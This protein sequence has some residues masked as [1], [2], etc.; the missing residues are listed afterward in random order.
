M[1]SEK[2]GINSIDPVSL[3]LFIVLV[4]LGWM[5]IYASSYSE[6]NPSI[7]DISQRYGKQLLWIGTALVLGFIVLILDGKVYFSL[8]YP[9]YLVSMLSLAGVLIFGNEVAGAR[10]WYSIGGFSLQP[11]EFAKFATALALARY[12]SHQNTNLRRLGDKLKAALLFIIPAALIIPQ[13]DPGSALI[14][15]S[16]LLVLYR[17]GLPANYIFFGISLIILFLLSLLINI[18]YLSGVLLLLGL[19]MAF[20]S[21]KNRKIAFSISFIAVLAVGFVHSVDYVF[22]NALEDRHRNRINILIGKAEDPQGIGYNTHQSMIA[23]G[24]GGFAGKGFLEGTQTKYNFVPEQSTDFIFCT[25]GEEWGFVGTTLLI[26]LYTLLFFRLVALAERQKSTF[27]RAYGYGLI[28]ILFFHF[29]VNIAMTIGLAPVIGIPLPFF[30]YGG[31]SL[32]GFTIL[33]FIF[34]K[35]DAYRWDIL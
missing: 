19:F 4:L 18:W 7:F 10:S 17:E 13:P 24:S 6:A 28:S 5:N 32:W 16:F 29:A 12:L 26:L 20:L 3:L 22:E 1:R 34:L 21:R 35:L 31:S 27:S 33:F 30:S 23:I 14:F 8:A 9:I 2:S 11:S 15:A 25:V